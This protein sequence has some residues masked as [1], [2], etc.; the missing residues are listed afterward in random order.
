M[1]KILNLKVVVLKLF[2]RPKVLILASVI[3]VIFCLAVSK[4]LLSVYYVAKARILVST[5]I[6]GEGGAEEELRLSDRMLN[7]TV[8]VLKSRDFIREVI[9]E[10][11]LEDA[12]G[13]RGAVESVAPM[14]SVR[15]VAGTDIIEIAVRSKKAELATLI[16]NAMSKVVITQ[17]ARERFSFEDDI[18]SWVLEKTS[19]MKKELGDS[20]TR[21]QEFKASA[22]AADLETGYDAAMQRLVGSE[23]NLSAARIER[24]KLESTYVNIENFLKSG[25]KREELPQVI[26]DSN[27]K[28]M[29]SKYSYDKTM[30]EE[31]LKT[32]QPNHPK[33]AELT[34][35]L[36]N[37]EVSLDTRAKEIVDDIE[38]KYKTAKAEEEVLQKLVDEESKRVSNLEKM[39]NEYKMLLDDLKEKEA[40]FN[41]F[42]E[43]INKEYIG[44]L[45]LQQLSLAEQA[46]LPRKKEGPST[47][48]VIFI[49]LLLGMAIAVAYNIFKDK[50]RFFIEKT[51]LSPPKEKPK[52]APPK[53][54]GMYI[55]R[56][57]EKGDEE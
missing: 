12:F 14:V 36:S 4:F 29:Q 25:K 24:E 11:N 10:L 9:K 41:T 50:D 26:N 53:G 13:K 56:V 57:T 23:Q 31:L 3:A 43:K 20:R 42:L 54:K 17:S 30:K 16:A 18:V 7:T 1:M 39:V 27:F 46:Y 49:G 6:I 38:T 8:E 21:L 2:R 52:V 44:G 5:D 33:V 55:E 48:K 37:L 35:E 32:Y 28:Q 45:R 34:E 15:P 22:G 47:P 40:I 19:V 51:N